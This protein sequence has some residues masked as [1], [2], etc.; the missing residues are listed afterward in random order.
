MFFYTAMSESGP[1][2]HKRRR[3]VEENIRSMLHNV[4]PHVS[5]SS[6]ST[7]ESGGYEHSVS[8]STST[9]AEPTACGSHHI[10]SESGNLNNS[11]QLTDDSD[12]VDMELNSLYDSDG[13]FESENDSISELFDS[14]SDINIDD[15]DANVHNEHALAGIIIEAIGENTLRDSLQ[16]WAV[17]KGIT[18][19]SLRILLRI[20][21]QYHP[22][23]PLDP[24]TLLS[25]GTVKG[26][27]PLDG[28]GFYYHFGV[29]TGTKRWLDGVQHHERVIVIQFNIDG[30]PIFR[31]SRIQLWPI[32]AM[33]KACNMKTKPFICALYM[34]KQKPP[35]I[36]MDNFV[37]EM[38]SLMDNGL[39]H[40]GQHYHVQIDCFVCDAPARCLVKQT[41]LY[42][43]YCGCDQC[44][45]QGVYDGRM[46]FPEIGHP[47]RTDE[48]FRNR[49][50]QDHH[51]GDSPLEM[52]ELDMCTKFPLDYMHCVLLGCMKKILGIWLKG[53]LKSRLSA[54]QKVLLSDL[55]VAMR[56]CISNDFARMPRSLDEMEYYKATEY[57]TFLLYTGC[58]VLKG[59]LKKEY[60]RNFLLLCVAIRLLLVPTEQNVNSAEQLLEQFVE[61]FGR[62]YGPHNLVYNVHCLTHLAANVREHGSLED[63]SAFPYENFLHSVKQLIRGSK[64]VM[65]QAISRIAEIE[66][67]SIPHGRKFEYPHLARLH[68]NGP[69]PDGYS[70][71]KQFSVLTLENFTVSTNKRNH[72]IQI[73]QHIVVV[74][75]FLELDGEILV[76][77]Q[78]FSRIGNLFKLPI[79]SS[80]VGIYKASGLE[81]RLRVRPVASIDQKCTLLPYRKTRVSRITEYVA[82]T[83]LHTL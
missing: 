18:Q 81:S 73:G 29:G 37:S 23:L 53:P 51:V 24:R 8:S 15:I 40:N 20:L 41:K 77:Y 46:T 70:N 75:N 33:V 48:S 58:I 63:F 83:I 43:G 12:N 74:K 55:L 14:L 72:C 61:Q 79:K 25:T 78:I 19:A 30:L 49:A 10:A 26:I 2:R 5:I 69:V 31:S 42:S 21:H 27:I 22:E 50:Q 1:R 66:A 65:Q 80:K 47:P 59:V 71:Y 62:L 28:G 82:I 60:Y 56:D 57:R 17:T 38:K 3:T 67:L 7:A 13:G 32:L 6:A 9:D 36:F 16:Y 64:H 4:A 34:G 45:Q 54:N 44:T 52:L 11:T 35:V 68:D 76:V 39:D